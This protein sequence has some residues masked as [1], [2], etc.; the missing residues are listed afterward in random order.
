MELS[1]K[2]LM[3]YFWISLGCISFILGTIGIILPLLPTVPFYLL[4]LYCFSKGSQRL[5]QWFRQ[6]DLYKK[7]LADFVQKRAMSIKAKFKWVQTNQIESLEIL[8]I[9]QSALFAASGMRMA[10]LFLSSVQNDDIEY[11][12]QH[13]PMLD[14]LVT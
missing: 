5:H 9:H 11:Q 14:N 7:H 12:C 13:L 4:T 8:S 6:T 2:I 3:R 10:D 1:N